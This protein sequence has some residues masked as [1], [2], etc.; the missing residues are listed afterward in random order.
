MRATSSQVAT[1]TIVPTYSRLASLQPTGEYSPIVLHLRVIAPEELRDPVIDVLRRE[2][3]VANV[4]LFPGAAL[5]PSGDE[6][7]AD[8]AREWEVAAKSA[9]QLV[10][11]LLGITVAGVLVLVLRH[12]D[13][14][15]G[16]DLS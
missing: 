1:E 3:G 2:V 14:A 9:A 8:V 5:E 7:T 10:V 16:A 15:L 11:N 4:L 13:T 6:I 12:L